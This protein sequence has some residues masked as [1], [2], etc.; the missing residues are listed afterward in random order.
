MDIYQGHRQ[1]FVYDGFVCY[2]YSSMKWIIEKMIPELESQHGM[3]L[4]IHHRDWPAGEV[5]VDNIMNSIQQSRTTVFIVNKSFAQNLWGREEVDMAY[6]HFVN[7]RRNSIIVILME[8]I[9]NGEVNRSLRNLLTNKTYLPWKPGGK[10]ERRFWKTLT[11][12]MRRASA[13]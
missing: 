8:D 12:T 2:H 3:K 10:K 5:I 1:Q 4:C 7:D 13:R 6:T 9:E 11:K